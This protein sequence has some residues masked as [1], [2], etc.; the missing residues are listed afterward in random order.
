[1]KLEDQEDISVTDYAFDYT[2]W[3]SL[4]RPVPCSKGQ[5]CHPGTAVDTMNQKN[6]STPQPCF[7]SMYCPEGS[8]EPSGV[9]D[10]PAGFYCPFGRKIM[11]PV[12]TFCSREGH[13]DPLP[14]PPGTFNGQIGQKRCA[15]C[16]RGFICPG[17][18]ALTPRHVLRDTC[19]VA[20]AELSKRALSSW[21]LCPSG[22]A[23]SDLF[24]TT[25]RCAVPVMQLVLLGWC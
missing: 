13:W 4:R 7:E 8:A 23:T 18:V 16:S 17:L 25:Q 5:Y 9:A 6:F 24:E 14:C 19:A 12:G 1:M 2:N 10:C 20:G 11:C 15:P 3:P 21:I 22:C